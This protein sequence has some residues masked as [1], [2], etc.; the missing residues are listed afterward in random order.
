MILSEIFS[1]WHLKGFIGQNDL[2]KNFFNDYLQSLPHFEGIK[3]SFYAPQVKLKWNCFRCCHF[4]AFSFP[5]TNCNPCV[6]MWISSSSS[7]LST[8]PM[9]MPFQSHSPPIQQACSPLCPPVPVLP[10]CWLCH[11]L[12]VTSCHLRMRGNTMRTT[13]STREVSLALC[14]SNYE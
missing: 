9:A 5:H 12:W 6:R 4:C 2:W 10:A 13:V 7:R 14:G 1:V 11:Q 3:L 8:S